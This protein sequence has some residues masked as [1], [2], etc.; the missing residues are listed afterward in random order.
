V[1]VTR[2]FSYTIGNLKAL[3]QHQQQQ[4]LLKAS[5]KSVAAKSSD[6][7]K[8]RSSFSFNLSDALGLGKSNTSSGGLNKSN[9]IKLLQPSNGNNLLKTGNSNSFNNLT[10]KGF[11]KYNEKDEKTEQVRFDLNTEPLS[12]LESP[13]Y[14]LSESSST[15]D[16]QQGS[17][18]LAYAKNGMEELQ[19]VYDFQHVSS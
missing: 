8:P 17:S 7:I 13:L 10:S 15:N 6:G 14:L 16:L 1:N 11:D 19:N 9:S 12:S 18:L 4:Q 3:R 2:S 5:G